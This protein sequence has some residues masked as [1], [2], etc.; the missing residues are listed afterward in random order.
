[1]RMVPGLVIM[2]PKDENELVNMLRTGL[3]YDNGPIAMRYPR[4]SGEGVQVTDQPSELPIGK[5][6]VVREGSDVAIIA[7]GRMV[8]RAV[9]AAEALQKEGIE[10]TVMNAR[11]I[12]PLDTELIG[13]LADDIGRVVTI[14]E[15]SI[16]G[17]F[18][19]GILEFLSESKRYTVPTLCL[20][21]P[22]AFVTYGTI[23]QLLH[24]HGLDAD[25]IA[26]SIGSFLR[27]EQVLSTTVR[28]A[29]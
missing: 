14:E 27:E 11:F 16:R 4:G 3:M 17:G 21:I 26:A 28:S 20:G 1:L 24:D 12:K 13:R 7:V 2:A 19:A 10:A 22:D 6:E 15:N 25:G 5:G 29:G 9:E 8:G 18:G 23:D